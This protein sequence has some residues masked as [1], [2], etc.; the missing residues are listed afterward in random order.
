MDLFIRLE[1]DRDGDPRDV[2][3]R[4]L[5][6]CGVDA[7]VT[8]WVESTS[9]SGIVFGPLPPDNRT[10]TPW[11]AELEARPGEW[12]RLPHAGTAVT[13]MRKR[14]P[15]FEFASR[16]RKLYGRFVGEPGTA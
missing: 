15:G 14:Y 10:S 6:E 4:H 16:T 5:N 11:K 3:V 1:V 9:D 8:A 13:S 12:A 2:A 7:M